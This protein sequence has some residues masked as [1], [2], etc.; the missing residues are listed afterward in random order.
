M[1]ELVHGGWGF[2]GTSVEP[3]SQKGQQAP[4]ERCG[5]G[6]EFTRGKFG[7]AFRFDEA[8]FDAAREVVLCEVEEFVERAA[9]GE[10][11]IDLVLAAADVREHFR[12]GHYTK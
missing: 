6:A 1:I 3:P 10:R 9:L 2:F 4:G 11:A 8:L 7:Q 5:A 12:N